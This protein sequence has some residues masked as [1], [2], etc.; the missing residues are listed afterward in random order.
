MNTPHVEIELRYKVEDVDACLE[1]LALQHIQVARTER[2][3]DQWFAPNFVHDMPAEE[4]WFDHDK[5]VAWRIRRSTNDGQ[6]SLD[7]TSKQLTN[8]NN[9]NSFHEVTTHYDSYQDAL[10][11]MQDLQ[12]YN[13]LTVDKTRYFFTSKNPDI[14]DT[15][16]EMV[17]DYVDGLA[18]KVG[19]GACLEI[20]CK[21]EATRTDALKR[22]Q[23]IA[24]KCGFSPEDQFEK[25]LTV[26]SM[27]A[28]AKFK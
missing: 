9:H 3:I 1:Q 7:V 14:S 11:A 4:K 19:V 20:E 25:S 13:W 12:Y 15:E 24:T 10:Q 6:E 2:L 28:L 18:A 17:L 27:S 23:Q 22:I 21:S 8:D 26:L 16:V 5:G